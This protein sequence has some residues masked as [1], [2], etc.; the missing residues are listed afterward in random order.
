M[1]DNKKGNKIW[2]GII[3][4]IIILIIVGGVSFFIF[5]KGNDEK[6]IKAMQTPAKDYF[7]NYMS[8]NS[9][10]NAYKVTL[11]MLKEANQNGADYDL[12]LLS[13]CNE[14]E[15]YA[16]VSVDFSNGGNAKEATVTLK[17]K[18]I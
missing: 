6:M 13:N 11:K 2:T 8:V 16:M 18:K 7:N 4:A 5:T 12:S 9:G 17:C 10:A 14:E 15:T 1:N 3:W